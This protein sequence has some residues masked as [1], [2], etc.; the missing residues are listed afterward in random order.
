MTDFERIYGMTISEYRET[1]GAGFKG[2]DKPTFQ[3]LSRQ[4]QLRQEADTKAVESGRE[5]H[6]DPVTGEPAITSP[7]GLQDTSIDVLDFVPAIAGAGAAYGT[8][9]GLSSAADAFV[10]PKGLTAFGRNVEEMPF[11][12][13][14]KTNQAL[15]AIDKVGAEKLDEHA[16]DK[17]A[18][19]IG[20]KNIG[21]DVSTLAYK[22]L[23]DAEE[24][25]HTNSTNLYREAHRIGNQTK[26]VNIKSLSDVSINGKR[27]NVVFVNEFGEVD[28]DLKNILLRKDDSGSVKANTV[29]NI[30]GYLDDNVPITAAGVEEKLKALKTDKRGSDQSVGY[31]YDRAIKKLEEIQQQQLGEI[32][33][34][35]A[36]KK[37]RSAY[38]D[39]QTNFY[40]AMD[41]T[42]TTGG[43]AISNV[44]SARKQHDFT[45]QLLSGDTK[46]DVNI[47]SEVKDKFPEEQL[48]KDMVFDVLT[49]GISRT[50]NGRTALNSIDG[51]EQFVRNY[52]A[53]DERAITMMIGKEAAKD[54]RDNVRAMELI[55]GSLRKAAGQDESIK[56]DVLEMVTAVMAAKISPYA[57]THVFINKF[58]NVLKKTKLMKDK[59]DLIKRVNN[60][61]NPKEKNMLLKT[62]AAA[63]AF[64]VGTNVAMS[65][66]YITGRQDNLLDKIGSKFNKPDMMQSL[67]LR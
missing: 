55:T 40:G 56:K 12:M 18:T 16:L 65:R 13:K 19:S 63:T 14:E 44:R 21:D 58:G 17:I 66:E 47:V 15:D 41:G 59:S 2:S 10:D 35:D 45:K 4:Q 9:K 7:I 3:E 36:Y 27:E 62:L 34:K 31:L 32:G 48:R 22:S 54:L 5:F 57:S 67:G 20:Q 11:A 23:D 42:G 50:K 46:L 53:A 61:K 64:G 37:A 49:E 25:A 1:N 8:Y 60:M 26:E 52:Y 29:R 30:Q 38:T 51:A 24:A 39:W 6:T 28:R 33:Q 43:Q